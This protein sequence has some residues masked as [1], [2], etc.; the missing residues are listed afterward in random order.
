MRKFIILQIPFAA[1]SI[2]TSCLLFLHITVTGRTR[3]RVDFQWNVMEKATDV[4]SIRILLRNIYHTLS[5]Q[6]PSWNF[7]KICERAHVR[8]QEGKS[9]ED[10]PRASGRSTFAAL[11]PNAPHKFPK[12]FVKQQN[13]FGIVRRNAADWDDMLTSGHFQAA[14][15][16]RGKVQIFRNRGVICK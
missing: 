4:Q 14:A 11:C 16:H 2:W 15:L 3:L 13:D 1:K 8:I 10:P 9:P 7:K 6:A 12:I 5:C